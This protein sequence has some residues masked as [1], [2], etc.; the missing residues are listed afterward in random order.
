MFAVV[1][2]SS[3]RYEPARSRRVPGRLKA[4]DAPRA[5]RDASARALSFP[6]FFGALVLYLVT[7]YAGIRSPD[8]EVAFE[9]WMAS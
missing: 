7:S 3:R 4:V 2:S 8:A 6:V 5:D 9:V 1:T